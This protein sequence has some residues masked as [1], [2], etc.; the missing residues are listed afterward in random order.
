MP[1]VDT[2][3]NG[4]RLPNEKEWEFAARGGSAVSEADF[5]ARVFPMPDGM[6][7]HV[8]FQ[9]TRSSGGR[10]RPIGMLEPNPLGVFD[11]LGNVAEW[12]LEPYR[13]NRVGRLHGQAGGMVARGGDFLTPEECARF[14]DKIDAD[15][16]KLEVSV[17][18]FGR[19]TPVELEFW[20]VERDDRD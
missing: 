13:L 16:G 11:I 15:R 9:G 4:Y 19:S 8:W 5:S 20:Q 14:V 18:I 1:T 2:T 3:A 17:D 6:Q 12:V 7:R 10:V